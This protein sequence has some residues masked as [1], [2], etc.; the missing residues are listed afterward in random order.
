MLEQCNF[1]LSIKY[2]TKSQFQITKDTY[3]TSYVST[4]VQC[5]VPIYRNT[6]S[7]ELKS[8]HNS[9]GLNHYIFKQVKIWQGL[10]KVLRKDGSQRQTTS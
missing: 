1:I 7:E 10:C 9:C 8:T 5:N 4:Q 6:L 3:S 2:V